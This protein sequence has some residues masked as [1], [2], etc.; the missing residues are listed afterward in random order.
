MASG[1]D[2]KDGLMLLDKP[3]TCKDLSF[4]REWEKGCIYD[5]SAYLR[6][7]QMYRADPSLMRRV[8]LAS[9]QSANAD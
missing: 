5:L 8:L 2:N 1:I 6:V 3:D 7:R 9:S 4:L